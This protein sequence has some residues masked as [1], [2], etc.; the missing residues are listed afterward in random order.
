MILVQAQARFMISL[1]A[2]NV[3]LECRP[4]TQRPNLICDTSTNALPPIE[5]SP[6]STIRLDRMA[7]DG[8]ESAIVRF[9]AGR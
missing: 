2:S 7:L 3:N 9:T 6:I 1:R 8:R 4:K 5:R